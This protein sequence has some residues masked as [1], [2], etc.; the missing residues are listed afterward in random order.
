[1][2]PDRDYQAHH[3]FRPGL[4]LNI[5][6]TESKRLRDKKKFLS[7]RSI[8]RILPCSHVIDNVQITNY[9]LQPSKLQ[10]SGLLLEVETEISSSFYIDV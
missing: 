2:S 4:H 7:E 3:L 5:L 10:Q 6:K 8:S 9:K 1:M